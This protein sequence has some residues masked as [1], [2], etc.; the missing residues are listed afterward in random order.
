MK[1]S[2]AI[3]FPSL[4]ALILAFWVGRISVTSPESASDQVP[5]ES[6]QRVASEAPER[7]SA[8]RR[9][10][11][12]SLRPQESREAP[13]EMLDIQSYA[14]PSAEPAGRIFSRALQNQSV[15]DSRVGM[16]LAVKA[17]APEDIPSLVS[18]F[19]NRPPGGDAMFASIM[20]MSAWGQFD[21]P[22]AV[23][24]AEENM[25]GWQVR[26]G[27][28]AAMQAWAESNPEGVVDWL[29]TQE[30]PEFEGWFPGIVAG[31]AL[32]NVPLAADL[33]NS[34]EYGRLRGRAADKVLDAYQRMGTQNMLAYVDGVEDEK[35]V[36][37]LQRKAAVRLAAVAPEQYTSWVM[38]IE[39][40]ENQKNALTSY[41]REWAKS[42]PIKAID[43][44][45]G[46]DDE[47]LQSTAVTAVLGSWVR[48]D[49]AGA[50]EWVSDLDAG[51]MK[52]TSL[53]QVANQLSREQPAVALEYAL[54]I[55][56]GQTRLNTVKRI[57]EHWVRRDPSGAK[58][59]LGE[60]S[61]IA[62]Q[63]ALKSSGRSGQRR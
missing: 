39:D 1:T 46:I 17:A 24:Y 42:D 57:T 41:V 19:E 34:M 9:E 40:A 47:S 4:A 26:I 50:A 63:N 20:L 13:Q 62:T 23:A 22:A 53:N 18:A 44:L 30:N 45:S 16:V 29:S 6:V 43:Y 35:L 11:P 38:G 27:A 52:D 54:Q 58:E 3:I 33:M 60:E 48:E 36:P 2:P 10:R 55:A 59:I 49:I 28:E 32:G 14:A 5:L 8:V 7:S 37:G 21:G 61:V 25:N 12:P 31:V 51:R 56:D 15:I